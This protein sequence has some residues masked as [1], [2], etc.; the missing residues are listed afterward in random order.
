MLSVNGSYGEG[1]GQIIRSALSLSMVTGLACE[2]RNIRAGRPKPGLRPQ[3]LTC[4]R[5]AATVCGAVAE[6]LHLDSQAVKFLPGPVR[7]GQYRFDVG[8]AGSV[9]LVL[10]TLLLPLALSGGGTELIL[11]G[12]T[13]VPWSPCFHYLDT[14]FRPALASMGILVRL[15]LHKWGWYPSG[16][17]I[18]KAEIAPVE[19][20][21]PFVADIN[22]KNKYKIRCLSAISHLPYHVRHRQAA[23][24]RALCSARRVELNLTEEEVPASCP[25]SLT[26]CWSGDSGRYAGYAGLGARGK[27]AEDVA[28][29]AGR[30]MLEFLRT[31]AA[32]DEYLSDQMVLPAALALGESRWTTNRLTRHLRTNLWVARQF[33]MGGG[34]IQVVLVH[35][36]GSG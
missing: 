25:G 19:Q 5:A 22:I 8:T 31:G 3:H 32:V 35:G 16:G 7:S 14:V 4:V 11:T 33:G 2:I 15:T 12:G 6:G 13:H 23:R 34:K 17:G 10:Q 24:I 28:E 21:R 29:E 9:G 30:P 1:G 18:M 26:F 20:I 36:R 27:P